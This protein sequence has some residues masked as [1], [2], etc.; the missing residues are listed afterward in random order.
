MLA[1][2]GLLGQ[3]MPQEV[4]LRTAEEKAARQQLAG[5][6][7]R[8]YLRFPLAVFDELPN[9][10]GAATEVPRPR[11]SEPTVD[12][13]ELPRASRRKARTNRDLHALRGGAA[14]RVQHSSRNLG[15]CTAEPCPRL[16]SL[17]MPRKRWGTLEA[18]GAAEIP[19]PDEGGWEGR[20]AQLRL[21]DPLN[22]QMLTFG[23]DLSELRDRELNNGRPGPCAAVLVPS[24]T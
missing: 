20:A 15:A 10:I 5:R 18:L 17:R 23:A 9:G 19:L 16:A 14:A 11:C 6:R 2:I 22:F 1:A 12:S 3:R 24:R 8:H 13:R 7:L 4:A 21:P